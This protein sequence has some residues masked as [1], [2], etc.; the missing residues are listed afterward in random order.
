MIE[1]LA[2]RLAGLL[3]PAGLDLV[4]P[5][6]TAAY[7]RWAVDNGLSPLPGFGRPEAGAVLI[8]NTRALWQRFLEARRD[9]P[10][11]LDAYVME[12]VHGA[13]AV[14]DVRSEVRFAHQ[15]G[16]RLV[17]MLQLADLSGMAHLGPAHL[18]IHPRHGPW[19][20]LRAVVVFDADPP[21]EPALAPDPCTGCPAP[22]VDALRRAGDDWRD[23]LAVRDACPEGRGSRYG[24]RQILYHYTKDPRALSGD[25]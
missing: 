21:S 10:D 2:Q 4:Q 13:R 22:C 11:P 6:G 1:A 23:W 17:S 3:W 8:G 12:A 15:G 25:P 18:A 24:E 19:F 14:L 9:I 20:A 5:F 7:D 16:A